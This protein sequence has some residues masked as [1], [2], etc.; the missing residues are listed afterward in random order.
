MIVYRLTSRTSGKSY[1][2]IT[3]TALSKRWQ[4]HVSV[5]MK[6]TSQS[7]VHAAIRLYG[8]NDFTIEVIQTET[9][10]PQACAAERALIVLH[11]TI[12]PYG[13]NLTAGGDGGSTTKGRAHSAE[14]RA[15]M[16]RTAMGVK[17]SASAVE[18]RRKALTG[19]KAG[20]RQSAVSREIGFR[21]KGKKR[22]EADRLAGQV[23]RRMEALKRSASS[24]AGVYPSAGRWRVRIMRNGKRKDIGTFSDI[25]IAKGAYRAACEQHLSELG[26]VLHQ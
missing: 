24:Y 2:G 15:K 23:R 8:R 21:N 19:R 16:S 17:K 18:N 25:E 10:R 11:N 14:T 7:A 13:Y 1:I 26:I 6:H 12:S 20:P 22:T 5:A 9:D 3:A 4:S